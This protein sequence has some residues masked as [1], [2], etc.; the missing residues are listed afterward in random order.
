MAWTTPPTF[1]DGNMYSAAQLNVLSSDLAELWGMA[2]GPNMPFLS[3]YSQGISLTSSNNLCYIRYQLRYLHYK[4]RCVDFGINDFAIWINGV[5]RYEDLTHY[6]P[7]HTYIGYLD[8]SAMSLTLGALYP[9]YVVA[10]L[11]AFAHFYLDGFVQSAD[12][13]SPF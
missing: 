9:L 10:T 7:S 3:L 13:A 6:T 2:Q 5:K 8:L 1:V 4:A 12:T 11:D